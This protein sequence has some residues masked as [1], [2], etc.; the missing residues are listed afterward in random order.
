M[1]ARAWVHNFP[2]WPV[3]PVCWIGGIVGILA[4]VGMIF[5]LIMLIDCLKR[6]PSEFLNPLTKNGEYDKII[7]ALGILFSLSIYFIGAIVYFFVVKKAKSNSN[8]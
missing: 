6:K 1:I 8:E 5:S 2:F 4:I 7:W 3:E